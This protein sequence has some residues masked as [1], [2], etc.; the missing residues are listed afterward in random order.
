[1]YPYVERPGKGRTRSAAQDTSDSR[2]ATAGDRSSAARLG[3]RNVARKTAANNCRCPLLP[4]KSK[5]SHQKSPVKSKRKRHRYNLRYAPAHPA[6]IRRHSDAVGR[7]PHRERCEG[8]VDVHHM[9]VVDLDRGHSEAG[10]KK[11]RVSSRRWN[12]PCTTKSRA[13]SGMKRTS[14]GRTRAW[15]NF[16]PRSQGKRSRSGVARSS[17]LFTRFPGK[18]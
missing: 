10:L 9:R 3:A 13:L 12:R 4:K 6:A 14:P 16:A 11:N 15:K 5:R 7:V 1:M 17:W 2:N 8:G 18:G